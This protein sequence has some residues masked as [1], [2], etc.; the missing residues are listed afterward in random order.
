MCIYK[1]TSGS[2]HPCIVL[3]ALERCCR[4]LACVILC[5]VL[6]SSRLVSGCHM[7]MLLQCCTCSSL[8]LINCL[9][10]SSMGI[11]LDTAHSINLSVEVFL[12][13]SIETCCYKIYIYTHVCVCTYIIYIYIDRCIALGFRPDIQTS[14]AS[15][16]PMARQLRQLQLIN[17]AELV[18]CALLPSLCCTLGW[19][20]WS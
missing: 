14:A 10:R 9:E 18:Q 7:C 13:H 8:K 6:F 20:S 3:C 17:A 12:A 1:N 2:R 19:S 15:L 4:L 16:E 11:F 5:G